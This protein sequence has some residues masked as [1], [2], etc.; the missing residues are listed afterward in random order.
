M[1]GCAG[2]GSVAVVTTG[3]GLPVARVLAVAEEVEGDGV[4]TMAGVMGSGAGVLV[5]LVGGRVIGCCEAGLN[6]AR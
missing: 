3:A 5:M 2:D 6:V 1:L 4:G